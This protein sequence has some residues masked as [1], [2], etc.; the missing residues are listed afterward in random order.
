MIYF[1]TFIFALLLAHIARAVPT[2]GNISS[3]EEMYDPMYENEELVP[4][5]TY[6]AT[7][8][9]KYSQSDG[10][11]KKGACPSL[12]QEFP[13]FKNFPDFPFIGGAKYFGPRCRACLKLTNKKT[14]RFTYIT[15]MDAPT[16]GFDFVL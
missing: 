6:K 1:T 13:L 16:T 10:D 14:A 15:A 5:L 11:T 4:G 8:D 12:A 9:T 3:P 2:C 7:W